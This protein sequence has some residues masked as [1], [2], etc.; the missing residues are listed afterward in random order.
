MKT[1]K[2]NEPADAVILDSVLHYGF[3]HYESLPENAKVA[4]NSLFT[5]LAQNLANQH[6][7][8]TPVKGKRGRKPKTE[9]ERNLKNVGSAL[10]T[11]TGS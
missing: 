2:K 6:S 9:T 7:T 4:L 5:N 8:T 10:Q 11:A 3:N 1:K